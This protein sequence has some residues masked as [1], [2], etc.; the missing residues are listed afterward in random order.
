V[1]IAA[2]ALLLMGIY[3][4]WQSFST[5]LTRL[6]QS[7]GE[8]RAQLRWMENAAAE[9]RALRGTAAG[10][11]ALPHGQ[12]ILAVVDSSAKQAGLGE[13]LSRVEPT[14]D[15]GVRVWLDHALFN[16]LV[17]WLFTLHHTYSVGVNTVSLERGDSPGQVNIRLTLEGSL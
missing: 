14:G 8:Q 7:V 13:A 1:V 3:M 10:P 9:I 17:S 16:D 15:K 11:A 5:R 6:E 12:S 4:V 2:V